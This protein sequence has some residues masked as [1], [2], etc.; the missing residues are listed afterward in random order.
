MKLRFPNESTDARELEV[1]A[2]VE[3]RSGIV[4]EDGID[5]ELTLCDGPCR[6]VG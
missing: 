3:G 5:I 6:E 4:G 2:E 1:E